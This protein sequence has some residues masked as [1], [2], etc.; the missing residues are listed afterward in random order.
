MSGIGA[1]RANQTYGI[2]SMHGLFDFFSELEAIRP[3]RQNPFGNVEN[4]DRIKNNSTRPKRQSTFSSYS[5]AQQER[6]RKALRGYATSRKAEGLMHAQLRQY[7]LFATL[8]AQI[9]TVRN[10]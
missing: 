9:Q 5:R 10:S 7:Q 3:L 6:D 1:I 2:A 8:E 4:N